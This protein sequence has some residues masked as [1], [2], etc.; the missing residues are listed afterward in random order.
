MHNIPDES[1]FQSFFMGGF[2]CSTHRLRHGRRLDMVAATR[3]DR[4]ALADY[5]RLRRHGLLSAREGLR[6]HLIEG[7]AGRHHF[8]SVAPMVRAARLTGVQ[9]MWDLMH[10]GWPDDVDVFRPAFVDRFAAMAGAFARYLK[11]ESDAPLIIAPINEISF[12]SWGGGEVG[13]VNPFSEERGLELKCQLVRAAI[14]AIEA[15]WAVDARARIV[16]NESACH[17]VAQ[18]DRP[19]DTDAAE[20][21]R[22]LQF[23][24]W[25][26][27]AGRV[28]PQIGGAEKYLDILGVNYHPWN[29]WYY[30]GPRH[31][32]RRIAADSAAHRPFSAMLGEVE[33]RYSRPMVVGETGAEAEQRAPWLRSIGGEVRVAMERGARLLGICLYPIVDFPGW[34]DNRDCQN[35]MWGHANLVGERAAC[36]SLVTELRLQQTLTEWMLCKLRNNALVHGEAA[37]PPLGNFGGFD[38]SASDLLL[39]RFRQSGRRRKTLWSHAPGPPRR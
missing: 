21:V 18:T 32:G 14:A 11:N 33:R 12:L 4:F 28:W 34:D 2:E 25:D 36:Q 1:L 26:M 6:W 5:R 35:G 30:S 13:T 24:A 31:A 19:E 37:S 9:V 29:Q 7:S 22:Q 3:H 39:A 10:F 20:G 23:Q 27:I 16:H 38:A 15:V 8:G 17:V